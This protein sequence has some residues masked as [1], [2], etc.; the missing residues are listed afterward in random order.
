[1]ESAHSN[2]E[3]SVSG[4]R[5]YSNGKSIEFVGRKRNSFLVRKKMGLVIF[6]SEMK[7]EEKFGLILPQ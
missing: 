4:H 3:A 7:K 5:L 2:T 6:L 1:M